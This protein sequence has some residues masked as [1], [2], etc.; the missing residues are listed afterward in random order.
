MTL[1]SILQYPDLRLRNKAK[2]VT[3]PTSPE[4]QKIIADMLRTLANAES[5]AAL[6]ANQLDIQN[7]PAITV[8]NP[9]PGSEEILCLIN[10]EVVEKSGESIEEEGCMSVCPNKISA[11]IPRAEKVTVRALNKEGKPI[12]IKAEGLLA[13][14]LQHE[15]D[16]LNGILY[17]DYLSPL[18]RKRIEKKILKN[19]SH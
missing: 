5:C 4:V 13:R 3:D 17:I 11:K 18:K 19:I 7:P 10:P 8:I 14:C 6:A 15:I 12:E 2:V 1:L 16:H 9:M